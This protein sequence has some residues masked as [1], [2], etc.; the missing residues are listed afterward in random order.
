[1]N[2]ER[3]FESDENTELNKDGIS[4]LGRISQITHGSSGPKWEPSI[5]PWRS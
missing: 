3:S 2:S 4:E 5:V 1:M